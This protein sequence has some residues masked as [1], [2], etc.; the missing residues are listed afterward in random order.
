MSAFPIYFALTAVAVSS[1]ERKRN[2][3]WQ[4]LTAQP[5]PNAHGITGWSI[6]TGSRFQSAKR[7]TKRIGALA[8]GVS[9]WRQ[10]SWVRWQATGTINYF[11]VEAFR[12][13]LHER[14]R[15]KG[16]EEDVYVRLEAASYLNSVCN[17]S[18][19]ELFTAYLDSA[20]E[21]NQLEAV[22]ALGEAASDQA[23]EILGDIV[24]SNERPFFLRG[25]AAWSL[26]RTGSD[27]A[28][29]QLVRCFANVDVSLREEALEGLV[30]I[31][32]A[33]FPIV[34][35]GMQ[36]SDAG[37]L[38]GC[39]EVLRRADDLPSDVIEHLIAEI[40]SDD[41]QQWAVWLVAH[42]PRERFASAI[43]EL[44]HRKPQ[45]HYA[46]SLLWSF[47]ES[48]IARNWELHP[49]PVMPRVQ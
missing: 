41:P 19:R 24:S 8:G 9:Y 44:Q 13:R 42:L 35:K 7:L 12:S 47:V 25:A 21:Q 46:I 10:K 39:A 38:A 11:T 2:S 32:G 4:C 23:V 30:A 14:S 1:A 17:E 15:T 49:N 36:G 37:I 16:V 43:A 45:L 26:S 48:W 29:E 5:I 31:G 40:N 6:P 34:L 18:A 3:N 20:D 33:A 22:I 27:T 28:N